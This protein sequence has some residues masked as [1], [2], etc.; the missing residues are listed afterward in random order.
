[1]DDPSA[2]TMVTTSSG[3]H[4][5]LNKE[6]S[7]P[8][9]ALLIP[10]TEDG[11]VLFL[12]PWQGKTLVGTTDN[13]AKIEENPKASEDDINYILRH[14]D[15]Y[16]SI[17]VTRKDVKSAWSGLRPLVSDPNAADTAKLSRDHII[18][19]S[20]SGL[21]TIAGG[22]WTTYRKM[23]EDVV[24]HAEEIAKLGKKD[25]ITE[26]LILAGGKDF[27]P[28][29]S[30]KLQEKYGF[31]FDIASHLNYSYGDRATMVA[32]IAADG[33]AK[34][35]RKN[36]PYLEAEV[37][38]GARYESARNSQDILCRRTRLSFLST[39]AALKALPKVNSILAKELN[40]SDEKAARDLSESEN[41]LK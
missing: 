14:V 26:T 5:V 19:V 38:Y 13:P 36:F 24:D 41:Y 15:K 34:R 6:F 7:P 30:G 17:P 11:R 8:D 3:V 29:N 10:E 12:L 20:D 1:M 4:I 33:Y 27:S 2:T 16:F 39:R 35:L 22:K 18:N 21:L 28:E 32:D 23:A 9:T 37:V 40:W 31:D 25:A